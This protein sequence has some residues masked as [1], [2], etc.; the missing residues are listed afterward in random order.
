M[1]IYTSFSAIIS[2]VLINNAGNHLPDISTNPFYS[3]FG[4][5]FSNY[6][7]MVKKLSY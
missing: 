7:R 1:T 5:Y 4:D 3:F 6:G 2:T